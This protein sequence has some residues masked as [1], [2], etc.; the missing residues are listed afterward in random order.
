MNAKK[1]NQTSGAPLL[2]VQGL[3]VDF[4]TMDGVV[5]AVEGVDLDINAGRPSRSWASPAR[6]SR[7]RRWRSSACSRVAV[8]SPPAA[9]GSTV[10]RSRASEHELRAIR[11]RDIGL[12]PQDPMSNLKVQ[13]AP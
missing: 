9:S 2:S 4:A 7:P 12:V 10:V 11:G 3:A 6:A 5:H 1:E 8:A 13:Q